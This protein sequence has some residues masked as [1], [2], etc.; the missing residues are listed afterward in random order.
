[1]DSTAAP[2][3]DVDETR[4]VGLV[5]GDWPERTDRSIF[6]PQSLLAQLGWPAG[7]ATGCQAARARFQDLLR[8]A[9]QRVTLSAFTLED[10]ALVSPSS[11]LDE[12]STR[13]VCVSSDGSGAGQ[14]GSSRMKR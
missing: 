14:R 11:L 3:A 10:D 12:V 8:L 6:Y 7:T 4:I 9:R 5:D 2:F 13:A 1:M